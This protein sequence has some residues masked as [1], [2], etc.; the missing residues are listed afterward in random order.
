[1]HGSLSAALLLILLC[2]TARAE[3]RPLLGV[4]VT[5]CASIDA[6]EV[7]VIV[8]LELG[9]RT[10]P[11]A[12]LPDHA[13][14]AHAQ[15]SAQRIDI[16]VVDH[17]TRKTV[18]RAI[19]LDHVHE[20][21]RTRVLA[22]AIAEL[23]SASWF[24]LQ[25]TPAAKRNSEPSADAERTAALRAMEARSPQWSFSLGLGPTLRLSLDAPE[26]TWGG[27]LQLVAQSPSSPVL[28]FDV[29]GVY[30]ASEFALG[31]TSTTAFS[32]GGAG[33]LSAQGETLG[34][35]GGVGARAGWAQLYGSTN[36]RS[37]ARNGS[38]GGPWLGPMLIGGPSLRINRSGSLFLIGELG[39]ALVTVHG[40]VDGANALG[41]AAL[42]GGLTLSWHVA[43]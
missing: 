5:D 23:V 17:L 14:R 19:A 9:A 15:C 32:L 8:A 12:A 43:L 21:A 34:V 35:L 1:M 39:Y 24:E 38:V 10:L 7:R 13:T 4:D 37:L 3:D 36:D 11:S 42:W 26:R 29:G 28:F 6:E 27:S 33:L 22:I 2:A 30:A 18:K 20:T 41:L 31:S 16:E 40:R 25:H